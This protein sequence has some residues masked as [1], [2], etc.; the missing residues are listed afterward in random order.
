V[1]LGAALDTLR[2][3]AQGRD[4]QKLLRGISALVPEYEPSSLILAG[5]E[6]ESALE[7][8]TEMPA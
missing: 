7:L 3:A 1:E 6:K 4:L 2:E 5:R 8:A